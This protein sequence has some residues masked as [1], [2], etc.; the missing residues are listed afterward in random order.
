[1]KAVLIK[2]Y[3]SSFV[4][5]DRAI[6]APGPHEVLLKVIASGL[7]STDLHILAGRMNLGKLPRIP[8]HEIAGIIVE[9]GSAV[10]AWRINQR[11]TVA[12]DVHCGTC[13][14]CLTGN[15]QRCSALTR[16]GFERDGGHAEY[17][18]V[19]QGN[20]VSLP[21]NVGFEAG[22]ILPDAVACMYH[23]LIDQG[24]L[25]LHDK[26]LILGAGGLG[27]HGI[28]IGK[29]AGAEVIITSRN[30]AR[31]AVATKY[32]A[33]AVNPNSGDLEGIVR[34]MTNGEG[35]DI[36]ADCIG[37]RETIR[38]GLALLRPGGKVLAI[39]Y[40]DEEFAV[41]S[42]DLFFREKEIMGCRGSTKRDLKEVTE[43]VSK[44]KIVP[45][46]G[47]HFPLSEIHTAA[48]TLKNG[49]VIGRIVLQR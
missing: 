2:E 12:I 10:H 22:A 9:T 49:D 45:L 39:G 28:Q 48:Q 41:P 35:L 21:D 4:Y 24:K 34:E 38:Q 16:I 6:P 23:C 5:A 31:L 25:G 42:L 11:A 27:M 15:T 33:I 30:Q 46:I 40:L 20:L 36:V 26:I 14:H 3:G 18:V 47:K 13:R 37:T 44:G 8:G 32:G 29:L 7:C 17:V 43:L 19:P 1:M